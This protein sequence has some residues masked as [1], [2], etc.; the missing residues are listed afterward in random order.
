MAILR[1]NRPNIQSREK[2]QDLLLFNGFAN[3]RTASPGPDTAIPVDN[4]PEQLSGPRPGAGFTAS[5]FPGPR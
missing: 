2:Y 3:G 4:W 5:A 1:R